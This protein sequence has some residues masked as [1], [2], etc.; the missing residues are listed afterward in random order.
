M[1]QTLKN[2][3]KIE[4]LRKRLLFTFLMLIVVRFGSQ[5]PVPGVD[6]NVFQ[7]LFSGGDAM[8]F[9]DAIT[10][11]SFEQMSVFALNITPYIT[12]SIIMQLLTIAFPKLEEMQRD[13]QEGRKKIIQITR[14]VTVGLALMESTAMAIGFYRGNYLTKYDSTFM[15]GLSIVLVVAVLTA[16]S[17]VLMWIGE[18]ITEHGVG[19]GISIVLVIN[20]VS[21]IP[22]DM[23]TLF[24]QFIKGKTIPKGVL[25]AVI[26]AAV[27][28]ATV[29]FVVILQ[30]AERR[31]PVQYSKKMQGRRMYGGQS[32]H[33]PLRVNTG[34]VIPVIFAQSLLQTPVIIAALL[35]KGNGTGIGSKILRGMSQGNWFNPGE[36]IYSIGAAVYVLLI[37]LFAYFYTSITFNPLEIADNMKK[38]GGFIPGIRPGKPTSDYLQNILNYVV[39]IGAVGLSFVSLLPIFFNGVFNANVSFG[40][41]SI[42]I[43]VGV[44]IET[45]KAIESQMMV[46]NYKGFLTE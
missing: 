5:L 18:Q 13:G 37:I 25:A 24:N 30:N 10:G 31:I 46:R 35:N 14:Y 43:V 8:N 17:A 33:I 21:R 28:I 3:F 26:I 1:L 19:N 40:G 7:S 38:Q 4:D 6:P 15:T 9:F 11:G 39:F 34:G 44:V 2:A 42:I 36:W 45:L 12:S 27:I 23:T 32:S 29:I 16:G 20:I 22:S 41:T